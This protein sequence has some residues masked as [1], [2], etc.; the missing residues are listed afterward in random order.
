[1]PKPS[2][3]QSNHYESLVTR[4]NSLTPATERS[5]GKMDVAQMMAHVSIPLEVGLG[6]L[7]L[8]PEFSWPLNILVKWFVLSKDAFKPNMPTAK[9]FVV[10]DA[11]QFDHERQR[12]LINLNE[13]FRRGQAGG[14]WARHNIFGRLT[15]RQWGILTYMHLDHH[16]KQFGG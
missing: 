13:A 10:A 1:M 16:L 4:I 2:V 11:R 3:F 8:P 14:P 9:T 12:L 6:K 5:W 7:V 15:N